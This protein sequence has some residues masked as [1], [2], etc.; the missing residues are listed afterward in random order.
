[1]LGI[2]GF[3]AGSPATGSRIPRSLIAMAGGLGNLM[4]FTPHPGLKIHRRRDGM[5]VRQPVNGRRGFK[6]VR[7]TSRKNGGRDVH[8]ES[9]G[10]YPLHGCL[11][12]HPS[13]VA[14]R[15]QHDLVEIE[16]E[17]GATWA[18]PDAFAVLRDTTPVWIEGKYGTRQVRDENQFHPVDRWHR[19]EAQDEARQDPTSIDLFRGRELGAVPE[20]SIDVVKDRGVATEA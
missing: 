13:I 10:E 9:E 1:M 20:R 3:E 12:V 15:D 19:S 7:F 17:Q 6:T 14:Y 11:E 5:R 16:D 8:S 18:C 4:T 2:K